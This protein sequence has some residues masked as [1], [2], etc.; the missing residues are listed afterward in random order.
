MVAWPA[1][2][3]ISGIKTFVVS[4]NGVV[5]EKDLGPDTPTAGKQMNQFNP[6][7][8]WHEVSLE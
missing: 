2:Y 3:G 6:D 4:H 1:V 8:S 7:S 5:Y